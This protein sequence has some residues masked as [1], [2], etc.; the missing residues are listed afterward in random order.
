MRVYSLSQNKDDFLGFE[1]DGDIINLTRAISF[2]EITV[3]NCVPVPVNFS[4][5]L[6]PFFQNMV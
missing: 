3:N 6:C 2:Y 1:D 4:A 5:R